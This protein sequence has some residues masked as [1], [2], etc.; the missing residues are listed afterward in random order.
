[1][2][3]NNG[4]KSAVALMTNDQVREICSYLEAGKS[5]REILSLVNINSP[6]PGRII[7]SIRERSSW[8]SISKDYSFDNRNDRDMFSDDEVRIVCQML[9]DGFGYKDI[10]SKLGFDVDSMTSKELANMSDVISNIRVGRY[11]KDIS[12]DYNMIS[13]TKS[14]YDQIMDFN[15]I[16][17]VCSCIESG[18]STEEILDGMGYIKSDIGGERYS[19]LK[20]FVNRIRNKKLHTKISKDYNF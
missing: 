20:K 10:I 18:M 14:R 17:H 19:Y 15:E 8:K 7:R 12:A 6:D 5:I 2:G 9:Q 4:E 3:F 13:D 16:R 11:Y 1:M